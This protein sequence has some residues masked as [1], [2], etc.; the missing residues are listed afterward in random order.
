MFALKSTVEYWKREVAERN[1]NIISYLNEIDNLLDR[2]EELANEII[3]LK[4]QLQ[5]AK[6]LKEILEELTKGDRYIIR[7]SLTYG[8]IVSVNS[9]HIPILVEDFYDKHKIIKQTAT[10][11][12]K[13]D[14]EGNA[15]YHF[16]DQNPDVNFKYKLEREKRKN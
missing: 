2:K 1:K 10:K 14:K 12:V 15:T 8:N 11:V 4:Q 9:E 16:T 5:E 7:D 6:N 13:L 3:L